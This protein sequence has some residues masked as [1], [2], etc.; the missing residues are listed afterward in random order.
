MGWRP[1]LLGPPHPYFCGR[2]D[3]ALGFHW[4]LAK[5][6]PQTQFEIVVGDRLNSLPSSFEE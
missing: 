2:L 1:Q 6:E 5:C 4:R 3:G